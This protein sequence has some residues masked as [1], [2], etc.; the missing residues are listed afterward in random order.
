MP[1]GV[2]HLTTDGVSGMSNL[3]GIASAHPHLSH[4]TEQNGNTGTYSSNPFK[5]HLH[6]GQGGMGIF[7]KNSSIFSTAN[8]HQLQINTPSALGYTSVIQDAQEGHVMQIYNGYASAEEENEMR[9]KWIVAGADLESLGQ[10]G[11]K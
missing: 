11:L 10:Y 7:R 6:E 4:L 8:R 2:G 3:G 1:D 5:R 9:A